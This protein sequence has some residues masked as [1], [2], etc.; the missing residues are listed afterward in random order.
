MAIVAY[1]GFA[2]VCRENG[3]SITMKLF[4][5]VIDE[6]QEHFNYFD[7]VSDHIKNLGDTYLANIAGTPASTGGP[8]KGFIS[9]SGN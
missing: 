9:G 1:N 8:S 4:E 7:S 5:I 3:D 2:Q 6:E